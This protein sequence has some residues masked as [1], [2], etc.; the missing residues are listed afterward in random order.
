MATKEFRMK[1][2]TWIP[3]GSQEGV[4]RVATHFE[5]ANGRAACKRR[6]VWYLSRDPA[7]VS[8]RPCLIKV[9][10]GLVPQG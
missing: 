2:M 8:C 1:P 6:E 10:A 5:G 3:L 7:K 9:A 4:D